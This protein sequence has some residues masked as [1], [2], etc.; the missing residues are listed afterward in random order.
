[1]TTSIE[2]QNDWDSARSTARVREKHI[3]LYFHNPG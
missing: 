1:M 3:A 2:W